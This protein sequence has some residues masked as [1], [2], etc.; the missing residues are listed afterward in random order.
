MPRHRA[1]LLDARAR[2]QLVG[3]RTAGERRGVRAAASAL[4]RVAAAAHDLAGQVLDQPE[5][6]RPDAGGAARALRRLA[7]RAAPRAPRAADGP[8]GSLPP[9]LSDLRAALDEY[10]TRDPVARSALR[11]PRLRPDGGSSR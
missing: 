5:S 4:D 6:L 10:S 2:L 3:E 11:V 7:D 1:A 9:G 8:T